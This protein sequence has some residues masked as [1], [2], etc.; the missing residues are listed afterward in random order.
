VS[1]TL[2]VARSEYLKAVRSKAFV[3][4]VLLTPLLFGGG[5]IAMMIA[6]QAVD[7]AERRFVVVDRSERLWP[8]IEAGAEQRNRVEVRRGDELIGPP[9][10]AEPYSGTAAGQ[11]LEVELST[12]VEKG[13]LLGFVVLGADLFAISPEGDQSFTWHTNTP[14]YQDLP[15]W[16]ERLVNTEVERSRFEQAGLDQRQV[17]MLS[18]HSSLRTLG[19]TKQ[20]VHT[21]VVTAAEEEN[22]IANLL[23]PAVL[24]LMIFMLVMMSAPALMNNVLEEK[25]QKIAEV[26]VSSVPPFELLMGKLLSAVGISL[27]LGVIYV[28]AGMLFVNRMDEVPPQVLAALG[29]GPLAWFVLFLMLALLI[30]GSMFSGLGA[31]CSELQ[32]A[33]TMMMPAMLLFMLPVFFIGPVLEDPG[34]TL[35]TALSLFPP[36]TPLIM[37]LRV[38]IPPGVPWWQL[39]LALVLT[40]G[41]T[42]ACVLGAGKIFRLGILAQGQTPTYRQLIGWL[43]SR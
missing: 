13:E 15:N 34:S 30:F 16:I 19:L 29:P 42:V 39:A 10:I 21:G 7:T 23:V 9:W 14:T 33:Q 25:M 24:G 27:T 20:D 40:T 43:T 22:E 5:L 1:K 41:F 6:K 28:G 11:E 2:T 37:F 17:E 32:D 35:S 8:L 4:G 12:R 18:R 3:V 36:F 38:T 31:A 26:L